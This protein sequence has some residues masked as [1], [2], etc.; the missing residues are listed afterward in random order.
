MLPRFGVAELF[1]MP[2]AAVAALVFRR[3]ESW[4][5]IMLTLLPRVVWNM[6]GDNTR[7]PLYPA[8]V[9]PRADCSR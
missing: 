8:A 9:T 3:S 1:L 6:L 2:C 7:G 4:L 5:M